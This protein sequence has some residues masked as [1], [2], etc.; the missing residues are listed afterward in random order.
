MFHR[1]ALRKH[2]VL[3]KNEVNLSCYLSKK[4]EQFFTFFDN[5]KNVIKC[6]RILLKTWL[7]RDSNRNCFLAPKWMELEEHSFSYIMIWVLHI[8]C[9]YISSLPAVQ[10]LLIFSAMTQFISSL[11]GSTRFTRHLLDCKEFHALCTLVHWHSSPFTTIAIIQ[12]NS[13]HLIPT[14]N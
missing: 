13:I 9:S 11:Q 6:T 4:K 1:V 5:S 2:Y 8:K 10:E 12:W 3:G 7:N 14:S